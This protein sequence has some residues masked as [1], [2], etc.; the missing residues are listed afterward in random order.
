MEFSSERL[1][2][3]LSKEST[4][5]RTTDYLKSSTP[6]IG[7]DDDSCA[8]DDSSS[9]VA[10]SSG[11]NDEADFRD[12]EMT[13]DNDDPCQHEAKKRKLKQGDLPCPTT[14]IA[15]MDEAERR[16]MW[17]EKLCEWAYQGENPRVF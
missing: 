4:T 13:V 10:G 3:L 6:D 11:T 9:S 15:A 14:S 16:Q 7:D 1:E 8:V 2:V 17:R 12:S 5:Y